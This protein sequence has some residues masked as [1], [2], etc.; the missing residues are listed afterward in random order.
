MH[1]Y[2]ESVYRKTMKARLIE[3]KFRG[4]AV[5]KVWL[6]LKGARDICGYCRESKG[7]PNVRKLGTAVFCVFCIRPRSG[8][9]PATVRLEMVW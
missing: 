8:G 7:H 2:T 6:E 5:P 9:S 4:I 1:Q 3:D